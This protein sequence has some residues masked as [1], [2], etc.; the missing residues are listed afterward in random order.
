MEVIRD[1]MGALRG[2]TGKY[3]NSGSEKVLSSQTCKVL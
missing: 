1:I 2:L 3:R